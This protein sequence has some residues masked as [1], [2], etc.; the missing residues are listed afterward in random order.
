[1]EPAKS[2][3]YGLSA[4]SEYFKTPL[5]GFRFSLIEGSLVDIARFTEAVDFPGVEG[6][7]AVIA[8]DDNEVFFRC[9]DSVKEQPR[10]PINVFNFYYNPGRNAFIDPSDCYKDLRSRTL[11]LAAGFTDLS[12][13]NILEAAAAVS[14]FGLKPDEALLKILADAAESVFEGPHPAPLVQRVYLSSV[15]SGR[16]AAAGLNMLRDFGVVE[17]LWPELNALVGL[18]QAKEFHP[19]GDAWEHSLETLYHRKTADTDLS[20]ALLLHDVGKPLAES[21][22]GNRFNNHAQ[23]GRRASERFL[24]RLEFPPDKT[25]KISF[26]VENHMLPAAI[27]SMPAYRSE[28]AMQNPYFP[29]LL[30]VY[31]CDLLSSF[32]DPQ[33]YYDACKAYRRF[34]KNTKNPFRNADGKKL[35]RLYVE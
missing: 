1:M 33:G 12:T 8:E 10:H 9:V 22:D 18:D 20:L 35:L 15:V 25:E 16:F 2:Y 30:E 6:I 14:L 3:L 27:P 4:L 19:E 17:A 23:I 31:R 24:R 29:L 26:L 5:K 13:E 7:D 11:R 34:V 21:E 32:R 28:K